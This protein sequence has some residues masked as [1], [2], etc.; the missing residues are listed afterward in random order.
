M[1]KANPGSI[2]LVK[3]M[4]ELA[5]GANEE[6]SNKRPEEP[7]ELGQERSGG[8][9]KVKKLKRQRKNKAKA[10]KKQKPKTP[11]KRKPKVRKQKTQSRVEEVDDDELRRRSMARRGKDSSGSSKRK[12]TR[13]VSHSRNGGK[14]RRKDGGGTRANSDRSR[15]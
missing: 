3:S 5:G 4:R 11:K 12:R 15:Y 1:E 14:R 7:T 8:G 13:S 2:E 6:E 9:T 10:P